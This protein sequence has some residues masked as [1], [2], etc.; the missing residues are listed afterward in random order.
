M[1]PIEPV[2]QQVDVSALRARI[3]DALG[4]DRLSLRR[5]L[6][7]LARATPPLAGARW[8]ELAAAIDASVRRRRARAEAVPPIRL[9]EGLPIAREGEAI[10][11]AIRAHQVV[12]IAGET[13]SGKTTQLPLLALAAG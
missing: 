12:V 11:A 8:D 3:G 2:N 7:Q 13:G 5:R 4:R 6:D 1:D 9:D 10:V